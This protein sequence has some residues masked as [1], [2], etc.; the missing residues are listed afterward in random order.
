MSP[1]L[2]TLSWIMIALGAALGLRFLRTAW[3]T[4]EA[5]DWLI[6]SFFFLGVGIGYGTTL[7][8]LTFPDAP[9][10]VETSLRTISFVAVQAPSASIA[11]FTWLV[12]RPTDDWARWLAMAMVCSI[13]LHVMGVLSP[14]LLGMGR[15][16]LGATMPF[17]W[18]GSSVKALCFLWAC[19]ESLRYF[20]LSRRRLAL[21][22]ADPLVTNRFL[23]WS[24]WSGSAAM[25]LGM[26]VAYRVAVDPGASDPALLRLNVIGQLSAG[27]IC[28]MAVWLTF[29]P[30]AAY[31]RLVA[32]VPAAA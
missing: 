24:L 12:F 3:R 26:R 1:L 30:P 28:I 2:L 27:L 31:R 7:I 23:L 10:A 14:P 25:V 19:G 13:T 22:L 15:L 5:T 9:S 16:D 6:A 29:S 4:G 8:V 17:F 11:L 32:G 20:V 18:L 21:G